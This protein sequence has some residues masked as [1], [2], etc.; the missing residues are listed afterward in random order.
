MAFQRPIQ[1]LFVAILAGCVLCAVPRQMQAAE[2][3][4]IDD[5][6]PTANLPEDMRTKSYTRR[7]EAAVKEGDWNTVLSLLDKIVREAGDSLMMSHRGTLEQLDIE[8]NTV[9]FYWW[10]YISSRELVTGT[11]ASLPKEAQAIHQVTAEPQAQNL[12]ASGIETGDP[13]QLLEITENYAQTSVA[14]NALYYL[15]EWSL[16][17]EDYATAADYFKRL[18]NQY[19]ATTDLDLP[20]IRWQLV[21]AL[22]SAGDAK[23]AAAELTDLI[24]SSKLPVFARPFDA[25]TRAKAWL[26]DLEQ[27]AQSGGPIGATASSAATMMGNA[28][29]TNFVEDVQ[30]MGDRMA[31]LPYDVAFV[32]NVYKSKILTRDDRADNIYPV[33]RDDTI[34]LT[35]GL[36]VRAFNLINPDPKQ[37]YW[38]QPTIEDDHPLPD[39]KNEHCRTL[40]VSD[41]MVFALMGD[42]S[43][44]ALTPDNRGASRLALSP[45]YLN[46]Y[47]RPQGHPVMYGRLKWS[48]LSRDDMVNSE[49]D[50]NFLASVHI[51]AAPVYV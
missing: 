8:A 33:V 40:T 51:P 29:H 11:L 9:D 12:L 21:Q 18:V 16:Q 35:D 36:R 17:K 13:E 1:W 23:G 38:A 10:T 41:S 27:Q 6:S 4:A 50:K 2:H 19:Q 28:S 24:K 45:S 37:P 30:P 49:A 5:Q 3:S 39:T 47:E 14:D 31:Q 26:A 46:G 48:T 20:S 34:Y 44:T 7:A 15:G 42:S 22:A 32:G 43:D 25:A